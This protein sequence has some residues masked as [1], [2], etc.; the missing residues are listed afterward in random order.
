M[1]QR[2]IAALVAEFVVDALEE[3]QVEQGQAHGVAHQARVREDAR[4]AMV[5]VAAIGQAG[6]PV[7]A[8]QLH[9]PLHAVH[10]QHRHHGGEEQQQ[11]ALQL[12]RHRHRAVVLGMDR[13]VR[14]ALEDEG[15]QQELGDPQ[16]SGEQRHAHVVA[17]CARHHHQRVA[18]P[19][20]DGIQARRRIVEGKQ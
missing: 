11:R 17:Q 2:A 8:R 5:E 20:Y 4:H 7:G 16:Q 19:H 12:R 1:A 9:Q 13:A 10:D 6:E 18:A 15:H 14:H 3:V